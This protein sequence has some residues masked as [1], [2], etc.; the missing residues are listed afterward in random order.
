M[1]YLK[2]IGII[3]IWLGLDLISKHF[4]YNLNYLEHTAIIDSVLNQGISRSLPVPFIII[5]GVSIIGIGAMLRLYKTKHIWYII[6]GVLLAG[7]LG[8]FIDRLIYWGVRDFINIGFFNFPIFNIADILLT[9]GVWL[10]MLQ[11]ILE[12]KK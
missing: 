8:N 3:G 11:V 1:K 10:R 12:K 7:T 5:I 6:T 4:F 2:L 9:L